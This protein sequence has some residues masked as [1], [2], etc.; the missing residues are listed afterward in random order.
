MGGSRVVCNAI[1]AVTGRDVNPKSP[2]GAAMND[3]KWPPQHG[4]WSLTAE[5]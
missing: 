3:A 2:N 4:F 1:Y 5:A